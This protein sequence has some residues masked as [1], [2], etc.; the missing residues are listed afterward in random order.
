MT[1]ISIRM[2]VDVIED[3]KEIAPLLDFGGYQAL[4]RA[5]ISQGL[6][7]HLAEFEAAGLLSGST[8][9]QESTG[10]SQDVLSK[11]D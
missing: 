1:T 8:P 10:D 11:Q 7:K 6:R 2:P 5:Y 9:R 3:L 4:I